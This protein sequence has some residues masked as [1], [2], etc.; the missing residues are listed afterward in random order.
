[1]STATAVAV[2][3][4]GTGVSAPASGN[5]LTAT[6]GGGGHVRITTDAAHGLTTGNTVTTAGID[7]ASY[8]VVANPIT[9]Q[10]PTTFDLDVPPGPTYL[11]D[12]SGGTWTRV[13]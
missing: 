13:S 11:F 10:S 7:Q 3:G 1:M 6:D 12:G 2:A 5:V 4:G 8:N 9:V